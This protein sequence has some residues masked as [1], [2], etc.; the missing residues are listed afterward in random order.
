M[1]G[2]RKPDTK[3]DKAHAAR[4]TVHLIRR[5]NESALVEYQDEHG[6]ARAFVPAAELEPDGAGGYLCANP[7]EGIPYG[8]A[9]EDI[10]PQTLTLDVQALAGQFRGHGL[11]TAEDVRR[12]PR[13]VAA[14]ITAALELSAIHLVRLAEQAHRSMEE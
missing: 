3:P 8:A 7:H 10:F 13:L 6:P 4:A 2:S 1:N 12:D 11:W 14:L 5:K 9:W